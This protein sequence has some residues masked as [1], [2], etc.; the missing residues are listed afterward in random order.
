L[1]TPTFKK[2]NS[3]QATKYRPISPTSTMCEILESIIKEQLVHYLVTKGLISKHQ[4]A[5]IRN[6][7][8]ATNLLESINDWFV[9]LNLPSRTDIVYTD[10]SEAFDSIVIS[11]Y[12][13]RCNLMALPV[14]FCLGLIAFFL[15][16]HSLLLLIDIYHH[17]TGL[18]V[19]YPRV[20]FS[21]KYYE[22]PAR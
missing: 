18:S 13:L 7:S 1:I 20:P 3:C 17:F 11:N 19:E 10:F 9:S 21:V 4:H 15:I 14:N 22:M 16:E 8:T 2:G 12:Y 6:H 5:F